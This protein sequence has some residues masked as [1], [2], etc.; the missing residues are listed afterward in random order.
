MSLKPIPEFQTIYF[1]L[2]FNASLN[3]DK[4]TIQL[5]EIHHSLIICTTNLRLKNQSIKRF[6][7]FDVSL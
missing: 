3:A 2:D 6:V 4:N 7:T 5:S 1:N